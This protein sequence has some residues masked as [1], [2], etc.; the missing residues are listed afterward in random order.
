MVARSDWPPIDFRSIVVSQAVGRPEWVNTTAIVITRRVRSNIDSFDRSTVFFTRMLHDSLSST[1][2]Y[3]H[4]VLHN[5]LF[6]SLIK[7][8]YPTT[9]E[10]TQNDARRSKQGRFFRWI[11]W[12]YQKIYCTQAD[13]LNPF[14]GSHPR[15][16]SRL[17][18]WIEFVSLLTVTLISPLKSSSQDKTSQHSTPPARYDAR[19]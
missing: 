11:D 18:Q 17:P 13:F 6:F 15:T 16:N 2:C 1:C 3:N 19:D 4:S 12:P 7:D 5:Y 14:D 8:N 10:A 9:K